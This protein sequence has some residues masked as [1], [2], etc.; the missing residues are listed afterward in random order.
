MFRSF[1]DEIM[2]VL[3]ERVKKLWK[4]KLFLAILLN[5]IDENIYSN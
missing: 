3:G 5:T 1:G 2:Y 4:L